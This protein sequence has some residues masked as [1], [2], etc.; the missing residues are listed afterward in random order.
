MATV[1]ATPRAR[2]CVI[3]Q[4]SVGHLTEIELR[5]TAVPPSGRTTKQTPG[6]RLM[7]YHE[8][9]LAA[10]ATCLLQACRNT[11]P[12]AATPSAMRSGGTVTKLRR[13]VLAWPPWGKKGL[14][15]T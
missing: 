4:L 14:P 15:G 2:R 8:P 5:S 6:G 7:R 13:S 12:N 9:L 11:R 3:P 1:V 10:E